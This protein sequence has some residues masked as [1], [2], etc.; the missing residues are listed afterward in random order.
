MLQGLRMIFFYN[1]KSYI[2]T[3]ISNSFSKTVQKSISEVT[4]KADFGVDNRPI[5]APKVSKEALWLELWY[6]LKVCIIL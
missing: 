1:F 2:R 3:H 4:L 6:L 5:F